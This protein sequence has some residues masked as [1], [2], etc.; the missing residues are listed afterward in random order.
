[1]VTIPDIDNADE[2]LRSRARIS[3][4]E[5]AALWGLSYGQVDDR[6]TRDALG[7]PV[8]RTAGKWS[9]R[10]VLV[11]DLVSLDRL[12]DEGRVAA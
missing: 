11:D 1:M 8:H 12:D 2:F 9:H 4:P 6:A 3:L 10:F 5:L 7:I